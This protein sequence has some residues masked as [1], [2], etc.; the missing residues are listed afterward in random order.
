M[1][2]AKLRAAAL[3]ETRLNPIGAGHGVGTA[4]PARQEHHQEDLVESRPQPRN[5]DAFHAVD[6]RPVDQQH[7]AADVEHAG[8]VRDAEHVPGHRIA[9]QE[10]RLHVLGGAMRNPIAHHDGGCQ[11]QQN[12]RDIDRMKMHSILKSPKDSPM[13]GG[14]RRLLGS[15]CRRAAFDRVHSNRLTGSEIAPRRAAGVNSSERAADF[16]LEGGYWGGLPTDCCFRQRLRGT[17]RTRRPECRTCF[18]SMPLVFPI[19]GFCIIGGADPLVRAGR[20][21]PALA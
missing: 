1:M 8:R 13:D 3:A 15:A 16:G 4:Q 20:P 10:V 9:A 6:E 11:I 12:N 21:R 2:W 7:G 17:L 14:P 5:P 18:S 19:V